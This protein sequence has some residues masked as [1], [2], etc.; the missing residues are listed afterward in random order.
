MLSNIIKYMHCTMKHEKLHEIK[1]KHIP[2]QQDAG[3]LVFL[4]KM[5]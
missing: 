1:V 3:F 5:K 2:T 4:C